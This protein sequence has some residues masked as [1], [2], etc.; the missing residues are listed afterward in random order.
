MSIDHATRV[1]RSMYEYSLDSKPICASRH[2]SA[3]L[4]PN[5]IIEVVAGRPAVNSVLRLQ[6]VIESG[7][8]E[9]EIVPPP[10]RLSGLR[11]AAI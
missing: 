7:S 11:G 8:I 6:I 9:P 10:F 3:H 1:V 2:H 4:G 5:V